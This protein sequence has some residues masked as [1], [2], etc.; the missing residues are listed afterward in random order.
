MP[1]DLI[2]IGA[3]SGRE[4]VVAAAEEGWPVPLDDA[5][6]ALIVHAST[7]ARSRNR[8]AAWPNRPPM[9]RTVVGKG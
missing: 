7:S 3:G 5:A 1:R 2:V 4:V 9:T 8:L 6:I